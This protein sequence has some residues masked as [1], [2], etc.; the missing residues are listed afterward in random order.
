MHAFFLMA[1]EGL[2]IRNCKKLGGG[3]DKGEILE[4]L[5]P[6]PTR[7]VVPSPWTVLAD[8]AHKK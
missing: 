5:F 4:A 1:T 3:I 8:S 6:P 7:Q 2:G